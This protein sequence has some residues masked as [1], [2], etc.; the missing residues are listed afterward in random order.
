MP[1]LEVLVYTGTLT[2]PAGTVNGL[3]GA[4]RIHLPPE[5]IQQA[6]LTFNEPCQIVDE[7]GKAVGCGIAWRAADKMGASPK[8]R[9]AR[10]SEMMREAFGIKEGSL[11]KI[12]PVKAEIVHAAKMVLTDVASDP[13]AADTSIE[14]DRW[15]GRCRVALCKSGMRAQNLQLSL[16]LL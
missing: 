9:P 1:R 14:A 6:G 5:S 7:K 4:L 2:W 16:M 13:S 10:M 12:Q 3:E 8:S 11:V 15:L